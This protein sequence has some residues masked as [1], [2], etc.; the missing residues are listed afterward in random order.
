[1]E[2]IV[3]VREASCF[4]INCRG[5]CYECKNKH[6][7]LPWQKKNLLGSVDTEN[8]KHYWQNVYKYDVL[9]EK[10]EPQEKKHPPSCKRSKS[11]DNCSKITLPVKHGKHDTFAENR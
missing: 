9:D 4:C 10:P 1:M 5:G 2:G 3:E 7:V 6:L 8:I 11:Q